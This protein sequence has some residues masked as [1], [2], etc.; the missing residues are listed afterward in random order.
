MFEE[1]QI[2]FGRALLEIFK[3]G[4]FE[5]LIYICLLYDEKFEKGIEKTEVFR[6]V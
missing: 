4:I 2:I 1:Y 5:I 3:R 6:S